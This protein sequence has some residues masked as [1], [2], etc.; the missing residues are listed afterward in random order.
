MTNDDTRVQELWTYAGVRLGQGGKKLH[1]WQDASGEEMWFGKL[2]AH[3]VGAEY[4]VLVERDDEGK[5]RTVSVPAKFAGS[6]CDDADLVA[7]WQTEQ[8]LAEAK[9]ARDRA[10][11]KIRTD[12]DAFE[13]AIQPL[14]A[15]RAKS[16]R[17][18]A[19]RVAFTAMVLDSL[20][21]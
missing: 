11:R 13:L 1:A 21:Q 18:R 9:L 3:A 2:T 8:R 12:P 16:C 10:E 7:K 20:G 14:R 6:R 15:L 5:F 19:D 4:E 17:T